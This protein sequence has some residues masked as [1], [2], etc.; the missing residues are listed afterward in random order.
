MALAT[1]PRY[2]PGQITQRGDHAVVIGASMAG[3]LA[4]RVVADGFQ[5]VTLV[6]KDSLPDEPTVRNGVPQGR[7]SHLLL[8]AGRVT[9]E[10]LFPGYGEDLVAAGG[11]VPDASK[12]LHHYTEGDFL[13]TGSEY[14]PLYTATR[15]LFEQLVRDRVVEHDSIELREACQFIDYRFDAGETAVE[16]VEVRESGAATS[17]LDADLVVDATGRQSRTPA[18]LEVHGYAKPPLDE[19]EVDVGYSTVMLERPTDQREI[20]FV[21]ASAERQRGAIT[22]PVEDGRRIVTLLGFHGDYPPG[23]MGA[24][25]DFAASLPVE[26]FERL[27]DTRRRVSDGIE[28]ARFPAHRRHRYETLDR[29]PDGLVVIG[30]AICSFNP[31][32]GQGMTVAALEAL[33]LHHVLFS[34]TH[35]DLAQRFFDDATTAID[36]AW[37]I[38]VGSD[39]E[40]PQTTGPKPRGTRFFNWYLAQLL[41]TA[42]ADGTLRDAFYR[43]LGMEKRPTSLLHPSVAWRVFAP[44]L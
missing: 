32:Y 8:D 27:L 16:G 6:E 43:V 13:A 21:E 41:Q 42:H 2:D 30:D 44:T 37:N 34:G 29:F 3:L 33:T 15:P 39:F 20:V 9:L 36:T 12:D 7:H 11:L 23:D 40:Y 1:I 28:R 14:L 4:S 25:V 19:V 24:L 18:Q 31:V 35:D 22:F 26:Y 5:T 10:D 38:A 17:D